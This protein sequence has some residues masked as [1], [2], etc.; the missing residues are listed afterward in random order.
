[1]NRATTRYI[2]AGAHA[3]ASNAKIAAQASQPRMRRPSGYEGTAIAARSRTVPPCAGVAVSPNP[4]RSKLACSGTCNIASARRRPAARRAGGV[5]REPG[6]SV[7]AVM[8]VSGRGA[9]GKL[10][11]HFLELVLPSGLV[12]LQECRRSPMELIGIGFLLHLLELRDVGADGRNLAA[13]LIRR[14]LVV[15]LNAHQGLV[16][17]EQPDRDQ[18]MVGRGLECGPNEVGQNGFGCCDLV[19]RADAAIAQQEAVKFRL[20]GRIEVLAPHDWIER[21]ER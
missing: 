20:D 3:H 15:A 16:G 14:K 18:L 4:A 1:V 7:A 17:F 12:G 5:G 13:L 11:D 8:S 9:G 10:G 19:I 21:D 6:A 2:S